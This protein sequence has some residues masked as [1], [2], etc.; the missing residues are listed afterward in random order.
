MVLQS[1]V[2]AR[3]KEVRVISVLSPQPSLP[4]TLHPA[5]TPEGAQASPGDA[6]GH[7]WM[8][9]SLEGVLGCFCPESKPF[10]LLIIIVVVVLLIILIRKAPAPAV[11][12]RQP[13]MLFRA[14]LDLSAVPSRQGSLLLPPSGQARLCRPGKARK[15]GNR[16]NWLLLARGGGCGAGGAGIQLSSA[17]AVCS[18]WI[19]ET[20][21][22]E[23]NRPKL[24]GTGGFF[25]FFCFYF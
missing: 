4:P 21:G 17:T 24:K 1:W 19:W 25:F 5:P 16:R 23:N 2:E 8:I 22:V 14:D 10:I 11:G 12:A 3:D 7:G 18:P 9:Q 13:A 6:V 20:L 15:Q